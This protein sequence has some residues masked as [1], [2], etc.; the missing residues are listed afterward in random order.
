MWFGV[1]WD[2]W[3]GSIEFGMAEDGVWMFSADKLAQEAGTFAI[4]SF[5]TV[6]LFLLSWSLSEE[7]T[8]TNSFLLHGLT[9]GSHRAHVRKA[10]G[11][12]CHAHSQAKNHFP[13]FSLSTRALG[14]TRPQLRARRLL[15]VLLLLRAFQSKFPTLVVNRRPDSVR[16]YGVSIY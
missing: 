3:C 10:I 2:F 4:S 7:S 9:P 13:A 1:F 11:A 15:R 8:H 14:P 12:P 5:F 6:H 16:S